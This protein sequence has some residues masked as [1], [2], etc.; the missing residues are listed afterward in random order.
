MK[1][2]EHKIVVAF[3]QLLLE[4]QLDDI[5]IKDLL[6]K[7]QSSR[8]SFYN[9]FAN[10]ENL[11]NSTIHIA[12]DQINQ[13]LNKNLLLR[14][15]ITI[16]MLDQISENRDIFF[17]L[18]TAFPDFETIIKEYIKDVVTHSSIQDLYEKLETNYQMPSEF[19]LNIY[20]KTIQEII[21]TWIRK[22]FTEAPE[23]IADMIYQTV[24]I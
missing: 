19:A 16:E 17:P 22:G 15:P 21:F 14:K 12:L 13:V 3:C 24:L 4:K 8:S 18:V 1:K 20:V 9:Y 6:N 10:K 2:S 5:S 7:A 11:I 23:E